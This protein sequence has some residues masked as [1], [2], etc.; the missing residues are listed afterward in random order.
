LSQIAGERLHALRERE[1]RLRRA[2][3]AQHA[4]SR[5]R[6]AEHGKRRAMAWM[7]TLYEH[8]PIV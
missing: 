7:A 6:Q 5:T 3:A 8:P 1:M 4:L 2:S